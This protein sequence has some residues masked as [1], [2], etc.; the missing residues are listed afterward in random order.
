MK[1]EVQKCDEKIQKITGVKPTLFRAPYGDYNNSVV[2]TM[3]EIG[4]YTIQWD[5]ELLA[6]D[7]KPWHTRGW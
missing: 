6:T 1:E 4:H 2:Q 3:R 5:V 7:G